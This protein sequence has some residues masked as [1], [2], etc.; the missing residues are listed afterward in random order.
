MARKWPSPARIALGHNYLNEEEL[1]QAEE[2][3]TPEIV[4]RV[5]EMAKKSV[6]M[7][8][9]ILLWIGVLSTA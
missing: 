5:G 8:E 6:A 3:Y 4:K 7:V 1:K 2:K 9:W